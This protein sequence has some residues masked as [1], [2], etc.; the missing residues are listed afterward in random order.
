MTETGLSF[1]KSCDFCSKAPFFAL[2]FNC[3][4]NKHYFFIIVKI[5]RIILKLKIKNLIS[6]MKFFTKKD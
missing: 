6:F 1:E 3:I 5:G 4:M 2:N